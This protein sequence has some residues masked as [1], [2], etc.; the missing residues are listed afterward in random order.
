MKKIVIG[1]LSNDVSNKRIGFDSEYNEV[2]IFQKNKSNIQNILFNTKK[3]IA[4]TLVQKYLTNLRQMVKIL[5]KKLN[6]RVKVTKLQN[7]RIFRYGSYGI[8]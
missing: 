8:S 5:V 2:K 7:Q 3:M 4:K 1:L 6:S